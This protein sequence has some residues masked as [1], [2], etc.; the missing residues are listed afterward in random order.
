MGRMVSAFAARKPSSSTRT[1]VPSPRY[2]FQP[3]RG[4]GVRER[5]RG[6]RDASAAAARGGT[7]SR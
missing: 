4:F 6:A 7:G 1:V 3:V 5:D 2:H